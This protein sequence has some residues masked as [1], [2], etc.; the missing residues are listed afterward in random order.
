MP[1][2]TRPFT[3]SHTGLTDVAGGRVAVRRYSPATRNIP[4]SLAAEIGAA[5]GL[6]GIVLVDPAAG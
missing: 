5:G 3:L 2:L 1:L 4:A 6:V